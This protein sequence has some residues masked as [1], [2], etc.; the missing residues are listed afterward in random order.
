MQDPSNP[1][2]ISHSHNAHQPPSTSFPNT[3]TSLRGGHHRRA[4]SEVNF[5]IPEDLH[6]VSDPF[7]VPSASFEEMG[8]EDDL[9]CTYIDIDKFGSRPEG[10]ARIDNAGGG[11]AAE[12]GDGE[13][14]SRPR[15][16]HSNSVDGSSMS[17]GESLF[18]DTIEAKKAMAPDKLAELWTLDPKR[19]KR[20]LANRQ[21]AARSKERKA[22][23]ILELERK[24]QT[25]QTEATTLSAQLTLF[26][27]DTTG[28]TT[29]N[30]ELKLR[31]QAMEQQAQL[32]DA[33][34]EALK[35]EV[36]R[37]KIATGEIMT[38]SDAYNLGMH[39][40]P[41]TQSSF[42]S[43]QSQPGPS[44][45]Q[46]IQM[47]QFHPFPS[48]MLTHHQPLLGAAHSNALSDMLQ[49]DPLGRLQ[50]LDI[51]SRGPSLVK[52]EGPSISAS[53]SSSTF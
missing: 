41:Y 51:S 13:K 4:H 32:R 11:L 28:L 22:R 49:Q 10:D 50:G 48:N 23:Y 31:L 26:Q 15:H 36:E 24:V 2:P 19:A 34:N 14:S 53:E 43:H 3:A 9:F 45:S 18:V 5:R 42:F 29:E 38:S 21:S 27:R 35:K 8:S 44:E 16:R 52:S 25:L 47:P 1:N 46:N 39:H 40:V 6:L 12:S 37:L 7:D 20:I 30:T 33:L 17:R